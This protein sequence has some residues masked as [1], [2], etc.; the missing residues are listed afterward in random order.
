MSRLYTSTLRRASCPLSGF[1]QEFFF[2][3]LLFAKNTKL[4]YF[5]EKLHNYPTF[6]KVSGTTT[7]GVARYPKK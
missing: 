1:P 2:T 6:S 4:P 3:A 7:L 5:F